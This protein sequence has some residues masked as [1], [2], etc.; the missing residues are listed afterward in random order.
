MNLTNAA[1]PIAD[2]HL[3]LEEV[4]GEKQ[5]EWARAR[6]AE[7]VKALAESDEFKRLETRIRSILD[8]KDRI[9]M[10]S[11]IGDRFYNFWRDGKNP[12]GLWRRTTLEEYRK[13]EPVWE[14][15]LDLDAQI[16]RAHV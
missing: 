15:V 14:T 16:G 8:S 4:T 12:K 2:P 6:N 5:L 9:P 10:V 1:E 7:S 11:K 3:W 13:T